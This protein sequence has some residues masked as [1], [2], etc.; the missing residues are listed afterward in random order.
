MFGIWGYHLGNKQWLVSQDLCDIPEIKSQRLPRNSS[1]NFGA[2]ARWYLQMSSRALLVTLASSGMSFSFPTHSWFYIKLKGFNFQ[3]LFPACTAVPG[4]HSRW[5]QLHPISGN[6]QCWVP[7]SDP[8]NSWPLA[9]LTA[10]LSHTSAGSHNSHPRLLCTLDLQGSVRSLSR[11]SA[12][13]YVQVSLLLLT[14]WR[15]VTCSF[16]YQWT[17]CNALHLQGEKKE[18]S[19]STYSYILLKLIKIFL[20]ETINFNNHNSIRV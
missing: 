6:R 14:G 7:V 3:Q 2:Q 20:E 5:G 4:P 11:L 9:A 15:Q 17:G 18:I 13:I 16:L 10:V 19:E 12:A 8:W 1:S